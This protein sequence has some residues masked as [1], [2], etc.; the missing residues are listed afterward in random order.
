MPA[1]CS[2]RHRC[3]TRMLLQEAAVQAAQA[4][5]HCLTA[6]LVQLAAA[7]TRRAVTALVLGLVRFLPG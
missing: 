7:V 6:L 5:L 3:C 4:G 2:K 1:R